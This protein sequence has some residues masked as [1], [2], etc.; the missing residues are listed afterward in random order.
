M[1]TLKFK[2]PNQ[3]GRIFRVGAKQE[4]YYFFSPLPP[5]SVC[6]KPRLSGTVDGYSAALQTP[7]L[8]QIAAPAAV[9]L[10]GDAGLHGMVKTGLQA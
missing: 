2:H 3:D 8:L 5:H 1:Q 7:I 9:S 6:A 4:G 10:V